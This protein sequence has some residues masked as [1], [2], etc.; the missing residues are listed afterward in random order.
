MFSFFS[1]SFTDLMLYVVVAVTEC[2]CMLNVPGCYFRSSRSNAIY[3][4]LHCCFV[5]AN[6]EVR[7]MVGPG[8]FPVAISRMVI[9][10]VQYYPTVCDL[11]QRASHNGGL[12]HS[13]HGASR[14]PGLGRKGYNNGHQSLA[15][16]YGRT[17]PRSVTRSG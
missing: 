9:K 8:L 12:D 15:P 3:C 14:T 17:G 10:S 16:I 7:T 11:V 1:L 6:H 2:R 4:L 13:I 5:N